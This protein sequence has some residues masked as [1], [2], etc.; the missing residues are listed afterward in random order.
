MSSYNSH[1]D[2]QI[3]LN[4]LFGLVLLLIFKYLTQQKKFLNGLPHLF[5]PSAG[6]RELVALLPPPGVKLENKG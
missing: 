6:Q 2:Q 4:S 3:S 1:L 5:D